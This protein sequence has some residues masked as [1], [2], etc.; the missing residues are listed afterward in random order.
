MQACGQ[1]AFCERKWCCG[2]GVNVVRMNEPSVVRTDAVCEAILERGVAVE[3]AAWESISEPPSGSSSSD[4]LDA[5]WK[6]P[7]SASACDGE[8][9]VLA[10]VLTCDAG[11]PTA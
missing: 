5:D 2:I 1:V 3:K 9:T 7:I 10:P 6:C 8:A 4:M 11:K